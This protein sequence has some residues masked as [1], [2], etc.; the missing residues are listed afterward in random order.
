MNLKEKC[1]W[2]QIFNFCWL[3]FIPD[4]LSV[5]L[6]CYFLQ[7]FSVWKRFYLDGQRWK[8]QKIK[9]L[10]LDNWFFT[11]FGKQQKSLDFWVAHFFIGIFK[12]HWLVW[13]FLWMFGCFTCVSSTLCLKLLL[14]SNFQTL[15]HQ[16]QPSKVFL[17]PCVPKKEIHRLGPKDFKFYSLERNPRLLLDNWQNLKTFVKIVSVT[18]VSGIVIPPPPPVYSRK[19][20]K[21]LSLFTYK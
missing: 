6:L 16:R 5:F 21:T 12:I 8:S 13:I 20:E 17:L 14:F 11:T 7:I 1:G 19:R 4:F 10:R 18:S 15:F 2:R 9:I 3:S